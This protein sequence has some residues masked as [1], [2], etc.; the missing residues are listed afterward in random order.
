MVAI[1][2]QKV[3]KQVINKIK[4]KKKK[5]WACGQRQFK[6]GFKS[7]SSPKKVRKTNLEL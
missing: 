7:E 1:Q 4:S 3:Q 5:I 2:Q 6:G